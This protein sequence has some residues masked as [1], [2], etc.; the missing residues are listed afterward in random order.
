VA[1]DSQHSDAKDLAVS[2][3]GQFSLSCTVQLY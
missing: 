3:T 1:D 2:E